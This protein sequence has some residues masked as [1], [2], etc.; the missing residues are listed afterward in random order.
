MLVTGNGPFIV[1]DQFGYLS[2]QQKIAVLRD[3]VTGY[4][5]ADAYTPGATLQ[6]VNTG[7]NAVALTG[8]ATVWNGGATDAIVG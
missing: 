6:V 1:V 2:S 5:S 3:P 4:D 7:T 8:A